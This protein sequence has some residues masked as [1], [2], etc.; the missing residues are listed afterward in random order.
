MPPIICYHYQVN[1]QLVPKPMKLT[2]T[3]PV[4]PV[5]SPCNSPFQGDQTTPESMANYVSSVQTQVADPDSVGGIPSHVNNRYNNGP[6]QP[7][8][9][10]QNPTHLHPNTQNVQIEINGQTPHG[11]SGGMVNSVHYT[12]LPGQPQHHQPSFQPHHQQP[13]SS[14]QRTMTIDYYP[15]AGP[16]QQIMHRM[17]MDSQAQ[18][19]AHISHGTMYAGAMTQNNHA[20]RSESPVNRAWN[21]SPMSV[22]STNSTPSTNSDIPDKPPPPYP[23]QGPSNKLYHKNPM[24]AFQQLPQPSEAQMQQFWNFHFPVSPAYPYEETTASET[25]S[26]AAS[27]SSQSR[28]TEFDDKSTTSEQTES[29]VGQGDDRVRTSP[30]P[31]RKADAKKKDAERIETKVRQYSPEAYKFYMEQHVENLFKSCQQRKI[32]REQLEKEMANADLSEDAKQQIRKMLFQKESNHNRSK[33]ARMD[34]SMFEKI[35]TLGTGAFGEVALTRKKDTRVLY[36]M[37]TLRKRDVLERNQVAHVK[38]ERDML[39]EADCAWVVKLYYSFQ[40]KDNLY[41]IM[42]YIPGGDM[43]NLLIKEG[44]FQEPLARFY[45]AELVLA[46]ESVHSMGFIHRDI[47]PDNILIDKDG[48]IKLTDFGLCTGFRWTHNSKYYQTGMLSKSID[49][50]HEIKF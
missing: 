6:L 7:P 29:S 34:R 37:K 38:A 13:P 19:V 2:A 26:N 32:R 11:P 39:A 49:K 16:P 28:L 21:Q 44:I 30:K 20:A 41:F 9:H 5:Q 10:H 12:A 25:T 27:E 17:R 22:I 46:I 24:T 47:K 36:A 31:Q 33:R 48:H 43:M 4:S 35:K 45:I 18:N 15:K 8:P 1:S 50:T 42:D 14:S 40:D 3:A 23:G